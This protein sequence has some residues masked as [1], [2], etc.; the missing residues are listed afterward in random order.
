MLCVWSGGSWQ[1]PQP[2]GYVWWSV[3]GVA[4]SLLLTQYAHG[5]QS[6][7]ESV[8][9]PLIINWHLRSGVIQPS[10]C[11]VKVLRRSPPPATTTTTAA[12]AS[13]GGYLNLYS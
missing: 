8:P 2:A 5:E 9:F 12:A 1:M 13:S 4:T 10:R 3:N 11:S 7:S 6:T